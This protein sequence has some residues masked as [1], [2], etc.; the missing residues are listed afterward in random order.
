[1]PAHQLSGPLDGVPNVEQTADQR[2]DPAQLPSPVIYE[3]VRQ[4]P[5]PQFQF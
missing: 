1:V 5:F 2:L 4:W 3:P